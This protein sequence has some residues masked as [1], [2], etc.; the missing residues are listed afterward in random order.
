MRIRLL[1]ARTQTE[2]QEVLTGTQ[3][4]VATALVAMGVDVRLLVAAAGDA[5]LVMPILVAM[6]RGECLWTY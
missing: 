4:E 2:P 1:A 6:P 5:Q 3:A